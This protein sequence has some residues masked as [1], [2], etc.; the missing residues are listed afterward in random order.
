MSRNKKGGFTLIELMIVVAVISILTAIAIPMYGDY[1]SRAEAAATQTELAS[2]KLAVS[3]CIASKGTLTGCNT[4]TNGIP[5]ATPTG[6]FVGLP[7]VANGLIKG[8][9]RATDSHGNKLQ[10]SD[11]P[12][13]GGNTAAVWSMTGTLCNSARGLTPGQSDCP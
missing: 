3:S 10:F 2:L 4:G 9:S 5:V 12:S 8:T 6:G 11:S 13:M 7:S 1:T